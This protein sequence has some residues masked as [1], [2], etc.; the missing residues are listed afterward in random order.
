MYCYCIGTRKSLCLCGLRG[1]GFEL[2]GGFFEFSD[3]NVEFEGGTFE[4]GDGSV[5]F[6]GGFFEFQGGL[7]PK[8]FGM[9]PGALFLSAT[10]IPGQRDG[11]AG[12]I[13]GLEQLLS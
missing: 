13:F 8:G 6:E 11:Q 7:D 9:D 4:S 10:S 5:E 2:K 3:G 1:T 12:D